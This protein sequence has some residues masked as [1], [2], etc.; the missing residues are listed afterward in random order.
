MGEVLFPR[1]KSTQN[2]AGDTPAP[3]W[4]DR[5]GSLFSCQ[6]TAAFAAKRV[7]LLLFPRSPLTLS[8]G[9]AG[10]GGNSLRLSPGQRLMKRKARKERQI[11][12]TAAKE[13]RSSERG[14]D[15]PYSKKRPFTGP[16]PEPS[17]AGPVGRGGAAQRGSSAARGRATDAQLVPTRTG[18]G[19]FRLRAK[20]RRIAA[21]ALRHRPAGLV[22][23]QKENGG[24]KSIYSKKAVILR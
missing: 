12:T 13:D 3:V 7:P 11:R 6:R 16:P 24:R 1:R 18:R 19:P 20:R 23:F 4:A 22:F 8:A 21:V 17:A 5:G 15:F 9:A 14:A 2:A 10:N